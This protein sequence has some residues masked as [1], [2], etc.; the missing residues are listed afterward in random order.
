MSTTVVVFTELHYNTLFVVLCM[1]QGT[2]SQLVL[3]VRDQAPFEDK[4]RDARVG[5]V[6]RPWEE[7]R[8]ILL[9][10]PNILQLLV[11][12]SHLAQCI[13]EDVEDPG[14]IVN[15]ARHE[16]VAAKIYVVRKRLKA[17]CIGE[18]GAAE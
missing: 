15:V 7:T 4:V 16:D 10:Q 14:S 9:C 3:L 17:V 13:S 12:F 6:R 11:S 5:E 8:R 18:D 2:T 1:E